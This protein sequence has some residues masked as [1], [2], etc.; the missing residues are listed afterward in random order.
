VK[1][2]CPEGQIDH[3][4][5]VLKVVFLSEERLTGFLRPHAR[6]HEVSA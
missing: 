6:E 5:L 2:V 4:E 3:F 1:V